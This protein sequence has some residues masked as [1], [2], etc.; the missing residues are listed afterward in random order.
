MG[1]RTQV[2]GQQKPNPPAN[3]KHEVILVRPASGSLQRVATP[4]EAA[5]PH[6]PGIGGASPGHERI[7]VRAYQ[8]WEAQGRPAGTDRENWFEAERL[9]CAETR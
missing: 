2:K 8:L 4:I 5:V 7:A 9:L 1:K 3:E 6:S